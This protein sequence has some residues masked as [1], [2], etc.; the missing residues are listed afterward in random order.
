MSQAA[1]WSLPLNGPVVPTVY[2]QRIDDSLDA[3]LSS[4]SGPARPS[5]AVAGTIWMSTATAGKLKWYA[6]DGTADRLIRVMDTVTGKVTYGDG[7]AEFDLS[8]FLTKTGGTT[9]GQIILPASTTGL[10]GLRLPNGVDPSAP[11]DGDLW[12]N[13]T[14]GGLRLRKAGS[15]VKILDSQ[16]VIRRSFAIIADQKAQGVAGQSVPAGAWTIRDLNTEL[17]DADGIVSIASNQFTVAVDCTINGQVSVGAN[18]SQ[19]TS[20]RIYNVTDTV[21][22]G[23]T[24]GAYAMSLGSI[25]GG[26]NVV[27]PF[28]TVLT[29]GKTYRFESF[30]TSSATTVGGAKNQAG[31]SEYYLIANLERLQHV[32]V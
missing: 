26:M 21:P 20:F 14:L 27:T 22:V 23:G 1:N 30:V 28:S 15:T 19:V 18:S 3:L 6:F 2:S 10:A 24:I 16:A 8:A 7:A 4:H 31:M 11:T 12:R 29:A 25:A 13:D 9:T 32:I 5:Y 17:A